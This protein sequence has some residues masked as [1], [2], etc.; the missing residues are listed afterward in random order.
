MV[1]AAVGNPMDPS[2]PSLER[3]SSADK[4]LVF[5]PAGLDEQLYHTASVSRKAR[6]A[7][8]IGRY[9]SFIS[10]WGQG[11]PLVSEPAASSCV[12]VCGL[13]LLWE[14]VCAGWV[15]ISPIPGT[16]PQDVRLYVKLAHS[17][18][19]GKGAVVLEEFS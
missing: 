3:L 17:S 2:S 15:L 12:S 16:F 9:C 10:A 19:K 11:H 18:P 4:L 6:L 8:Y 13:D 1:A 7:H 14:E 5:S